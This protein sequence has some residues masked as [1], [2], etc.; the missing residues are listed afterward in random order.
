MGRV[1]LRNTQPKQSIFSRIS[2]QVSQAQLEKNL[3]AKLRVMKELET[4]YGQI[5]KLG[6]DSGFG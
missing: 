3:T 5:V 2:L 1:L 4:D 6:G